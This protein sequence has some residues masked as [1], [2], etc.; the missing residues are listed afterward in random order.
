MSLFPVLSA[1]IKEHVVIISNS[2]NSG[3]KR[4]IYTFQTVGEAFAV[5]GLMVVENYLQHMIHFRNVFQHTATCHAVT[6]ISSLFP[7]VKE[8]VF[9]HQSIRRSQ[10]SNIMQ[11]SCC[12]NS[13]YIRKR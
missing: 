4:N 2:N 10:V 1:R 12:L 13:G 11:E 3:S 5:P 6:S 7:Y 8:R 9:G